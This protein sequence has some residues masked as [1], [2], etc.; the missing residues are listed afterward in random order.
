M[1]SMDSAKPTLA[2]ALADERLGTGWRRPRTV[3]RVVAVASALLAAGVVFALFNQFGGFKAEAEPQRE[4]VATIDL[5]IGNP[6]AAAERGE[7]QALR[8]IEAGLLQL[9]AFGPAPTK[10]D[11]AKAQRLKQRYGITW[12]HKGD[13][14]TPV[15]QGYADGYNRIV[16]AEIERRD[17]KE[18]LDRLVRE[19][20]I[21]RLDKAESP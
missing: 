2:V 14:P 3:I 16:Q 5:R 9:Q 15:S 8:D 12:V 1:H 19:S 13:T 4:L 7:A 20:G 6:V 10:A 17:G 18:Q 11:A 21:P